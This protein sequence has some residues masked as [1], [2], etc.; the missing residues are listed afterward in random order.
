MTMGKPSCLKLTGSLRPAHLC[1]VGGARLTEN[2]VAYLPAA[3][4]INPTK[5]SYT[6]VDVFGRVF[7]GD[8]QNALDRV[9]TTTSNTITRS[10]KC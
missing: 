4:A 8:G 5:L 2:L 10:Q 3:T 7:D 6:N 9:S 1:A